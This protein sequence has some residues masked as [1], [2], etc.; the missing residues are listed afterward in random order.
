MNGLGD[1]FFSRSAIP[2]DQNRRLGC[3]YFVDRGE[4]LLHLGARPQHSLKGFSPHLPL[5][6]MMFP[7]E[8]RNIKGPF[9]NDLELVELHRFVHEIIGPLPHR[10][11]G[12]LFFSP[13]GDDNNLYEGVK[14]E[15]LG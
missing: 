2:D 7:L 6:K 11:Q 13:P 4:D 3:G 1:E 5:Q 14:R 8:G 12:M 15:D 10:L 9:Q